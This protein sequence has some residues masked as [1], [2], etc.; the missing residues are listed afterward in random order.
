MERYNIYAGLGGGF[1]GATYKYTIDCENHEEA[2]DLA[3]QAAIEEYESYEGLH[4]IKSWYECGEEY[5]DEND[6]P[7]DEMEDYSD[8]IDQMYSEELESW[9]DYYAVLTDEDTLDPEELDLSW[10]NTEV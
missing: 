4:G 6:I 9:I 3:Y 1:G 2:E 10:Y 7:T 8:D 5:C